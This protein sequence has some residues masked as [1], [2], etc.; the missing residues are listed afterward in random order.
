[1]HL[2]CPLGEVSFEAKAGAPCIDAAVGAQSR[3]STKGLAGQLP[4]VTVSW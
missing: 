4:L 3:T 1:M 2:L